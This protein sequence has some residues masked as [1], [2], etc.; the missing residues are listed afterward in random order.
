M[1]IN[2]LHVEK[3]A[4]ED[5]PKVKKDDVG[6]EDLLLEGGNRSGKTLTVNALLYALY[7]PRATLGVAPGRTSTVQ[8]EF[9]NGHSLERGSGGRSYT[10]ENQPFEKNE[11]DEQ[12]SEYLG[13]EDLVTLQFVH[14]E[15]DKLPLARLSSSELI[16]RIRRI[17]GGEIQ[18]EIEEYRQER[19]ELKH[20]IEQ[21]ERTELK[22]LQRELDEI[23]LG[24]YERRLEKIEKLQSLIDSGRIE[25]IKQRLLDNEEINEEL[26]SFYNRKRTI[27]QDLR[28]KNRKLRE[29]RRYTKKVNSLI[30]EAIEEL[31]C[32]VC[33]QVVE[34]DLAKRRLQRGQCPHCGRD[35]S[36]EELKTSLRDK[37][38]S[39][40]SNI[41]ELESTVSDLKQEKEEIESKIDSLQSSIPDLSDLNDLT[42]HTLEDNDYDISAVAERT[43]EE[44]KKHR[45]EVNRLSSKQQQF[46]E[47]VEQIRASL[48][49]LEESEAHVSKKI[50]DL[51][52]KSF[53]NT[54]S[55]FQER[56][57]S[58]YQELA[59]E[60]GQE[61]H[62]E[63]DGTIQVPGNEGPREYNQ[64][65]TGETRLLNIAFAHSI[66]EAQIESRGLNVVVLDEP[67]A[68]LEPEKRESALSFI[69]NSECQY[70]ITTSNEAVHKHFSPG[71]IKSLS[72]MTIQMTWDDF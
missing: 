1:K 45:Q 15:T 41:E 30:V 6:G 4:T 33:D 11:A 66:T 20:E 35:R 48:A 46:E 71:Q 18:D 49:E 12:I 57:S 69:Q 34:E 24:Q 61:I 70:I 42:K 5:Y 9:D 58:N 29:Q 28:K 51:E 21:T 36:L 14:S 64:L 56:W 40:G 23:N 17:S 59:E 13:D 16:T 62:I 50:D 39:A 31:T 22:P 2:K 55:E 52:E 19:E 38:E 54:I 68:N 32:P 60:L 25:T 44:L 67:F 3:F 27:E 72:T 47:D 7:G 65:S 37:I 63:P 10:V 8:V 43:E 26:D 53:R